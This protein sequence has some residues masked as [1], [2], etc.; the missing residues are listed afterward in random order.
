MKTP[1]AFQS[2][3]NEIV[4]SPSL[5]L[6]QPKFKNPASLVWIYTERKFQWSDFDTTPPSS[7]PQQHPVPSVL[8]DRL[9]HLLQYL[10]ADLPPSLPTTIQDFSIHHDHISRYSHRSYFQIFH[11]L[12]SSNPFSPPKLNNLIWNRILH[13]PAPSPSLPVTTSPHHPPQT[14]PHP[15]VGISRKCGGNENAVTY[16][17]IT[18]FPNITN[19]P[20]L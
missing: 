14:Q 18:T 4:E 1:R 17:N 3:P 13:P 10:P 12:N 6:Y 15:N 16:M 7:T 2:S 9:S 20:F 19:H 11:H 5:S 8:F